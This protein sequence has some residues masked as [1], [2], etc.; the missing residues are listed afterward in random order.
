MPTSQLTPE[1]AQ[2]FILAGKATVT[3]VS[4]STGVR[5]TF[6]VTQPRD[7]APHFVKVLTGSDNTSDYGFL[8]T[9]FDRETYRHG[10]RSRIG[11]DAP[12]ARAW[13]W[14]W[15]RLTGGQDLSALEI[16]HEGKCGRCGRKL[17]V[18]ESIATGI[19]PVCASAA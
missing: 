13:A 16:W 5:F 18:P 17:T 19:G 6:K 3:L 1:Q 12:S 11:Q 7:D 8:G 4:V 9:V 2:T 10:R 15:G 14:F